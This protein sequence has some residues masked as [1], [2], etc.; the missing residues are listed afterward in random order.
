MAVHLDFSYPDAGASSE[1]CRW[2]STARH[3]HYIVL[4][5]HPYTRAGRSKARMPHVRGF[6]H[7]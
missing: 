5:F 6:A 7:V 4:F 3:P 2:S 1:P